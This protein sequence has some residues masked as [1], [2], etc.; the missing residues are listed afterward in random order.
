ML[1]SSN[2]NSAYEQPTIG[3]KQ[4]TTKEKELGWTEDTH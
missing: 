2:V 4:T 1:I 3:M